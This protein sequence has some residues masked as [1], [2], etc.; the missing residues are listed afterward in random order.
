MYAG[1]VQ[2]VDIPKG[3]VK[4]LKNGYVYWI[5]ESH[6]DND[7]K[8]TVDNRVA[9]GKVDA[10]GSGKMYPNRKYEEIFGPVDKE[11][12]RLK[13]KY[14]PLVTQQAGKIDTV[15]SYGAYAAMAEAC[16][17][18][19]CLDALQKSFPSLWHKIFAV[20]LHGIVAESSTAQAFPGWAFDNYCGLR[21]SI[22]DSEISKLYG[23]ISE[24]RAS[25]TIF[26]EL[27]RKRYHEAFPK[28][29]ERVEAFDSTN[30]QASGNTNSRAKRGK[31]KEGGLV[32]VIN[33]A[34]YVDETTGIAQYYEH[35]DGNLLDKTETP[36]TAEKA[37]QLGFEK[38]F[39]MQDR[40]YFSQGN[41][42]CL[43][44]LGIGYGMIM[45]ET[46]DF[47][48]E[49]IDTNLNA[50]KLKEECYIEYEDIYGTSTSV[51]IA[52]K[53]YP[54]YVYYDDNTAK[55]ERDTIHGN[56]NYWLGE[57]AKRKNYTEKMREHYEKRAVKVTKTAR[58]K[59]TGKNFTTEINRAAV[60]ESIRTAGA[61]VILSNRKMT[62]GEMISIARKRDCVEKSFRMLKSHFDL[63][64]TYTHGDKTYDG[65]M[66]VAFVALVTLQSYS[67]FMRDILHAK[68]S[69]TIATTIAELR[70][71]KIQYK[72]DKSWM[73]LY[74]CNKQQ[75]EIL[76]CFGLTQEKLEQAVRSLKLRV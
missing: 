17:R 28:S 27:Y 67:W 39:L 52:G 4:I 35:F 14:A 68:T 37:V 55:M 46:A 59:E 7:R 24:D 18:C 75:K 72:S 1:L 36:Y 48:G 56:V 2:L 64:R 29:G 42:G 38:L 25:V 41:L 57:A 53:E 66:F 3:R 60:E 44:N 45:P 74:A 50:I 51:R 43:D 32:P 20:G 49:L 33:T 34:M 13:K 63:K 65:K 62:A 73:P 16:R 19:G 10:K 11:L 71:Y 9:I 12:D 30:Q 61:F 23:A 40:G 76:S 6:W 47:V 58:N 26:F 5:T 70:K 22:S 69:E 31:S 54:A 21:S 8:M 15:M